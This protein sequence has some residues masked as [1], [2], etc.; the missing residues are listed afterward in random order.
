MRSYK[1]NKIINLFFTALIFFPIFSAILVA[2]TKVS[3][4]TSEDI[5]VEGNWVDRAKI[6]I[7]KVE[8]NDW[9]GSVEDS[10]QQYGGIS[11]RISMN[12]FLSTFVTGDYLDGNIG[13]FDGSYYLNKN[14]CTSKI[15]YDEDK[16]VLRFE[17]MSIKKT[18][19]TGCTDILQ[20][21]L[22]DL[23]NVNQDG[24]DIWFRWQTKTT[25]H[26]VDGRLGD[27]LESE[28]DP[29][30][31]VSGENGENVVFDVRDNDGW[32]TYTYTENT[33]A[34][35]NANRRK[36]VRLADA[37]NRSNEGPPPAVPGTTETGGG[38]SID[39]SFNWNPMNWLTC[40]LV[41][42]ISKAA[43]ALY[44]LIT[45]LLVIP[46]DKFM[47]NDGSLYAVWGTFRYFAM[48]LLVIVG[49]VMV[50]SQALDL[51]FLDAYTIK[52]VLPRIVIAVIAISL[53]W[54]LMK[55]AI[56][57]SNAVGQ[58]VGAIITKPF[59]TISLGNNNGFTAAM[60][61][62]TT[63]G[64]VAAYLA[65]PAVLTLAITALLAIGI[66]LGVLIFRQVL[67][68]LLVVLAPIAIVCYILPNTQKFW[69]LWSDFFMRALLAFPIII[70]FIA[71]GA[72][73]ASVSA[74]LANESD[75]GM[76][77]L[78]GIIAF[79]AFFA[80]YFMIPTAFKLAGGAI[81]NIAGIANDRSRGAFDRL[82]KFRRERGAQNRE[83][84]GRR[85]LA[86]RADLQNRWQDQGS[87]ANRTAFGR[88]AYR[89]AARGVG[90]YNIQAA[91]S[92]RQ[93][94]VS[95]ELNDQ[96]ATGRDE[97]IRAL[98]VNKRTSAQRT[99]SNGIKEFQTLG[100]AWVSEGA[101]DDAY[102]RWGNDRYA[103][104]TALSYEMRKAQTDEQI[105]GLASN[106]NQIARG[107]GMSDN[108]AGGAWIGAAFENQNQHLEYKYTDWQSGTMTAKKASDFATEVYEK[109]GSYQMSQMGAN[110]IDSL[111]LAYDT[112]A[113][114]GDFET[115]KKVQAVAETFMQ[116]GGGTG[117]AAVEGE[118]PI[119]REQAPGGQ[120]IDNRTFYQTGAPGAAHVAENVRRLAEHVG[121]YQAD[122]GSPRTSSDKPNPNIVGR[123]GPM[124][125][126]NI[127]RQN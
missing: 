7:T 36:E 42:G 87:N 85:T 17:S 76:R 38:A 83:R 44:G 122:L 2:P 57:L 75:T 124:P 108:Q 29:G 114:E 43:E 126:P 100:G 40:S 81:A 51:N 3:A 26:R 88:F 101:V 31:Y 72:A 91:A 71:A 23:P 55:F 102:R 41:S 120:N 10:I 66:G 73:F 56:N 121:V 80:P 109:R 89:Q 61:V 49:L 111:K 48:A 125:P 63:T 19:N 47:A 28:P 46:V 58:D 103:Q 97:E 5:N 25:L 37:Q 21:D 107:W 127:P 50:I 16:D 118:T 104:Q 92:A 13:D 94:A 18:G 15:Y 84:I 99:N 74:D 24:K 53:S 78:Y 8:V 110:T 35:S 82:S 14:G 119:M 1:K 69:K 79:V 62:A 123:K 20:G 60:T 98:T 22:N 34:G 90:G 54:P 117:V 27:F 65:G 30:H 95:K 9:G 32:G 39:C 59:N 93:A 64:A 67:V 115:Q 4:A 113:Q 11:N 70:A 105:Q 77:T 86:A 106:Y 45:H 12:S 96:I 112:A 6:S 33:A 116:R 68:M 52:K